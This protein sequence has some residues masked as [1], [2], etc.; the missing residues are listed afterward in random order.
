[1][2]KVSVI[3]TVYNDQEFVLEAVDSILDQTYGSMEMVVVNDGSTDNT[4]EVLSSIKDKR[5]RIYNILHVGRAKALN[6]GIGK[7]SGEYIAIL[8]SDDISLTDRL[9]KQVEYLDNNQE[10]C[11]ISAGKRIKIDAKP[12]WPLQNPPLVATPKSPTCEGG[13]VGS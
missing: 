2:L 6:Y 11:L 1:V 12:G 8:D 7:S 4:K 9:R 5:V 10:T 13:R 3:T